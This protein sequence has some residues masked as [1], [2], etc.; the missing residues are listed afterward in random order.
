[1]S[2]FKKNKKI[3]FTKIEDKI[4]QTISD[5]PV[6]KR[7][8]KIKYFYSTIKWLCFFALFV[9]M[10]VIIFVAVNFFTFKNIYDASANAKTNLETS[11]DLFKMQ[12]FNRAILSANSAKVNFNE[13]IFEID[14]LRNSLFGKY[15]DFLE[16]QLND[17]EYLFITGDF[18]SRALIQGATLGQE[19]ENLL[20]S[21]KKI[22]YS[23]FSEPEKRRI[24]EKLYQST[25]ELTG[26][27]ANLELALINLK[28]VQADLLFLPIKN[29]VSLAA[30]QL[31]FAYNLLE[32]A[33]PFTQILPEIAGYPDL[34]RFLVILQNND[35]LRPTGGFIGTYGILEI[36]NGDIKNFE[37][38]D[39][40]HLDMP[41][42]NKLD[43][44]P[45]EPLLKYLGIDNWYMRDANWSPD[46]P[47][48]AEKILWFYEK[49]SVLNN[50]KIE[51]ID[52][53]IAV[54]PDFIMDLMRFTGPIEIDEIEFNFKNF[55]ELLQYQVEQGYVK[56]GVPKWQRK[57]IIGDIAKK[58]KIEL[59]DSTPNQWRE[60]LNIID[61]NMMKKNIIFY[62]KNPDLQN[63]VREQGWAG[64]IK[65]IAGDYL[66]V[67]DAN[68]AAYKTD[69]IVSK[70]INY[71]VD[72]KT[73]GLYGELSIS[74][75]HQ[76]GFDWRTTRYRT[77]TRIYVPL[78]SRLVKSTGITDG[79]VEVYN[80]LGRTCFAGFIS[81][82]PGE[83]GQ[84]FFSYK[85]P[86]NLTD[87]NQYNLYIQKQPGSEIDQLVVD[88]S[89]LNEV[90]SYSPA[91]LLTSM[92]SKN[93]VNWKTDLT[94]DKLFIINF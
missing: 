79:S 67:V 91:T 31:D 22:T 81:V 92:I 69:A 86:D 58:L 9:L 28:K 16:N 42:Q 3:D 29:D 33:I 82:E 21:D 19:L 87:I 72:Q 43:V 73:D 93:R 70:N 71:K 53:V 88:L 89:F 5:L 36:N 24:L 6:I 77:Y 1:M 85:L 10:A 17:L 61:Q 45:P 12:E 8:T 34:S 20:D 39:I 59:F 50:N 60:L 14:E 4:E 2:F 32:K 80:E 44:Q 76:G 46:W 40:Y 65:N 7:R 83:I 13:A 55:Q 56:T 47:K 26:I 51:P 78:G 27:K 25:P 48:S 41:I 54:T 37:T 62:L 11:L 18:V 57:E 35:E 52:G 30:S 23:K 90:K 64:E 38:H 68:M 94:T 66:M 75:S 49:E 74:Y 63:I 15:F 84:L